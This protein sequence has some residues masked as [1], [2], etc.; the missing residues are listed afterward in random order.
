[1]TKAT[2]THADRDYVVPF[3]QTHVRPEIVNFGF[4]GAL[5]GAV[6]LGAVDPPLGLLLGAG[7]VVA[8]HR[9]SNTNGA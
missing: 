2:A 4:W 9:S 5:V 1:M 7:V 3:T 8:R 6:A